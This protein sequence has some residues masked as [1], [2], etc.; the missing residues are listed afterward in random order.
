MNKWLKEKGEYFVSLPFVIRTTLVMQYSLYITIAIYYTY[1]SLPNPLFDS[2]N[3]VFHG[4]YVHPLS[5]VFVLLFA[6]LVRLVTPVFASVDKVMRF[7]G[8]KY[9]EYWQ[10]IYNILFSFLIVCFAMAITEMSWDFSITYYWFSHNMMGGIT[11]SNFVLTYAFFLTGMGMVAGIMSKTYQQFKYVWLIPVVFAAY[12][13]L[14]LADGFHIST[15]AQYRFNIPTNLWELGHWALVPSL[16]GALLGLKY[17][18]RR[19]IQNWDE[20]C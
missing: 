9:M 6:I 14:W 16:F 13:G 7:E 20:I 17:R 2:N 3:A 4:S 11:P 5:W 15:L 8:S 18:E 12:H 19:S 1:L 10:Y